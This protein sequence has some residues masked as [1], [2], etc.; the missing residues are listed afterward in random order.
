M[1]NFGPIQ[2]II[3]Q[4]KYYKEP[5]VYHEYKQF[6]NHL[7]KTFFLQDILVY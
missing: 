3:Y 1:L 5:P 7:I 4:T 2:V 6:T